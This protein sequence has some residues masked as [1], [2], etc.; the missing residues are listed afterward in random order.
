MKNE[1]ML[2]DR[3]H[4]NGLMHVQVMTCSGLRTASRDS[5]LQQ[6][7]ILTQEGKASF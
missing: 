1:R 2:F 6:K 5:P 3:L 7:T 4:T